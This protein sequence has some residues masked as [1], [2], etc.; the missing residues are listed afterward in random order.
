VAGADQQ[1]SGAVDDQ[2]V[3]GAADDPRVSALSALLHPLLTRD[4]NR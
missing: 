1:D 2:R 4:R 3:S